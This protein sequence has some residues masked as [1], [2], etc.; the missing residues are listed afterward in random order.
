MQEGRGR[1]VWSRRDFGRLAAGASVAAWGRLSA[2][3]SDFWNKKAP[4][5]W[6]AS[7]I[8]TLLTK[9]PWAKEVTA[10]YRPS[11]EY[12][13]RG[14][15]GG[16]GR[17][18]GV[19]VGIPGVGLPRI[20]GMGGPRIGGGPGM[21]G[22]RGGGM[23]GGRGGRGGGASGY[24]GT[25]QW[26]SAEPMLAALKTTLPEAF[27]NHYVIRVSGFPMLNGRRRSQPDDDDDNKSGQTNSDELDALKS[28]TILQPKGMDYAEPGVVQQQP[29]SGGPTYLFGF[30]KE[31]LD[32]TPHVKEVTF[33]TQLGSLIVK[34]KFEP[35][36][37][38]YHG[39]LAV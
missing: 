3:T 2:S 30:A 39:K 18:G 26:E 7:E 32:L 19:G 9:S 15:Q 23:G 35:K 31:F 13:G 14:G 22:G 21:G 4:A 27:A 37:M 29:S 1:F 10:Q 16:Q 5:D 28:F 12:G 25:V 17:G 36:D 24:K 33:S 38:L 11:G 8:D 6:S 20:G 34:A